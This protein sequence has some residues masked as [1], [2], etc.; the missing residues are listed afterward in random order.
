MSWLSH[1]DEGRMRT[2]GSADTAEEIMGKFLGRLASKGIAAI[3]RLQTAV[4]VLASPARFVDIETLAISD[5]EIV[6][7]ACQHS[8]SA[9]NES[10][11]NEPEAKDTRAAEILKWGDSAASSIDLK[12]V[13]GALQAALSPSLRRRYSPSVLFVAEL[14]TPR[15]EQ[16][17]ETLIAQVWNEC[18]GARSIP[19]DTDGRKL[20]IEQA[21]QHPELQRHIDAWER[22]GSER[23]SSK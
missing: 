14:Q 17:P 9:V 3:A 6:A 22:M 18:L 13:L 7:D 12:D 10:G 20:L 23:S 15:A 2:L 5:P 19:F 1:V 8:E 16:G 11:V 21:R 4:C